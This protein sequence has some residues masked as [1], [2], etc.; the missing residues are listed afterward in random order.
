MVSRAWV[1]QAV[2]VA[3]F[4]CGALAGA[5]PDPAAARDEALERWMSARLLLSK[6][7]EDWRVQRAVL[8]DRIELLEREIAQYRAKT[9]AA[10][11]DIK[12]TDDALTELTA[13]RDELKQ[14]VAG[15]VPVLAES[16]VAVRAMLPRV[17]PAVA[18]R[19]SPLSRRIPADP[20]SSRASVGERF[21]NVIG[22]LNELNKASREIVVA[23]EVRNLPDGGQAEVTTL[24]LGLAQ[25]LYCNEKGG[26]GGV[27]HPLSDG[28][29]WTPH[30]AEAA[31]IAEALA[32]YR[33]EK[34]A[35]YVPLPARLLNTSQEEA[36]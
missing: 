12:K 26:I 19:V 2:A 18:E 20:A 36:P 21:Q 33:N 11:A 16:E 27:G 28:W 9:E 3:L 7:R 8:E 14:A 24:Y 5:N 17:P 10:L 23:G 25:A 29:H 34:P 30:D 15:L 22:I 6:E 35:A 13:R 4:S 1:K 32:I 31:K